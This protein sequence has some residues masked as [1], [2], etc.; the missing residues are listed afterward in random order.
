LLTQVS[1][2]GFVNQIWDIHAGKL[3]HEL[4]THQAVFKGMFS[5]DNSYIV[6]ANP[7]HGFY[8]WDVQSGKQ[9]R[10][11]GRF[12]TYNSDILAWSPDD[13]YIAVGADSGL[14]RLLSAHAQSRA[15]ILGAFSSADYGEWITAVAF[16]PDGHKLITGET[17]G[18][19]RLWD[20]A[21]ETVIREFTG[22]T[23]EVWSVSFSLDGRYILSASNDKT[24]R[25]WDANTGEL[26]R[27]LNHTQPVYYADFSSDGNFILSSG[28]D[29]ARL[30]DT[31]YQ[32]TIR[33]A[34]SLLVRDFTEAERLQYNITDT[35]PT[36]PEP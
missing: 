23:G 28:G 22:H 3:L 11:L 17:N 8:I 7:D 16:S 24:A 4:N 6:I 10:A 12:N 35:A 13:N 25:I 18:V 27:T 2:N 29:G 30:W 33:A 26:V 31:D 34:C 14:T 21:T 15:K 36:C 9:I 5:P 1:D 19:L 20:L 32:D